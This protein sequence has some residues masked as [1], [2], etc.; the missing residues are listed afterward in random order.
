MLDGKADII[1]FDR[2]LSVDEAIVE[3]EPSCGGGQRERLAGQSGEIIC[4]ALNVR[5]GKT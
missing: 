4:S 1:V 2:H 5:G 3:L